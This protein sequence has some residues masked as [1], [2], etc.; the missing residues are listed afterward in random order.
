[1]SSGDLVARVEVLEKRMTALEELPAR[2]SALEVQVL[3]LRTEMRDEFSAVRQ[4]MRAL[5]E[6]TRG[7]M[8][9]LGEE[10]RGE[11]RALN[12][13]TLTQVRVLHE[14]VIDR[15]ARLD[16]NG[17]ARRSNGRRKRR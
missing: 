16:G 10:L 3:Q 9:A 6:A 17:G 14:E 13:H 8:R 15:I 5:N 12:D 4:E 1:M 2:V 11:M 7:E